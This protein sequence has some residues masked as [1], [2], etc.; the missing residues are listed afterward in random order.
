MTG[1][2]AAEGR[3]RRCGS[4]EAPG[5]G[6]GPGEGG[7]RGLRGHRA[8][9]RDRPMERPRGPANLL[10]RRTLEIGDSSKQVNF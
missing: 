1:R 3:G 2:E 8:Y 6:R 4:Q 5:M 9:G 7:L 10:P